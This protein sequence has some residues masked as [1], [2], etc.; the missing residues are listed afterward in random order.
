MP[1]KKTIMGKKKEPKE[2]AKMTDDWWKPLTRIIHVQTAFCQPPCLA[3]SKGLPKGPSLTQP[4]LPQKADGAERK[5]SVL[6]L[7]LFVRLGHL[8]TTEAAIDCVE[9]VDCV[10]WVDLSWMSELVYPLPL[11]LFHSGQR[12]TATAIRQDRADRSIAL[13]LSWNMG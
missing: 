2:G 10:D 1:E 5:E 6:K 7:K 9:W 3:F 12:H 11:V 8:S 13:W 4:P